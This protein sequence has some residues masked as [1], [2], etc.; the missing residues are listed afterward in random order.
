M[1]RDRIGIAVLTAAVL[2]APAAQ[3]DA[4]REEIAALFAGGPL[5]PL[6]L[7]PRVVTAVTVA[8]DGSQTPLYE[9]IFESLTRS[10]NNIS[11]QFYLVDGTRAWTAAAPDGP[12]TFNGDT[13]PPDM[14]ERSIAQAQSM[15]RNLSETE[16]LGPGNLAG[17]AVIA[18]RCRTKVDPTPE[19]AWWGAL[20]TTYVDPVTG[21][22][23]RQDLAQ[24]TAHYAPEPA[25]TTEV[26]TYRHDPSIR[27]PVPD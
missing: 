16:C 21:L 20:H 13:I 6:A 3:A 8:P 26:M 14:T 11:G 22:V 9:A 17:Q 10:M 15:V 24:Q 19:G 18:D 1:R 5:D 23:V 4:C 12:W 27:L 7:T 25:T 2:A